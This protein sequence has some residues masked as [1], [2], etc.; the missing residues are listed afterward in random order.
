MLILD[1]WFPELDKTNVLF[2]V[3]LS[4]PICALYYSN[5]KKLIQ[6]LNISG[7]VDSDQNK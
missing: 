7:R 4:H 3:V 1:F 5:P 2:F 6:E